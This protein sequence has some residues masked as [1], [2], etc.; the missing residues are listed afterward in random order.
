M[1]TQVNPMS[2]GSGEPRVPSGDT[3]PNT[4]CDQTHRLLVYFG[5]LFIDG[6]DVLLG[7]HFLGLICSDP[8][9]LKRGLTR[10]SLSE[11]TLG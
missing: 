5:R 2:C 6:S 1:T 3:E 10:P 8:N 4:Q 9:H 11:G 7:T